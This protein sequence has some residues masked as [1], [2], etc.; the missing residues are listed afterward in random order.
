LLDPRPLA[1]LILVDGQP[2]DDIAL[3]QDAARMLMMVREGGVRKR[4]GI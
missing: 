4:V 1:D 2:L 3:L